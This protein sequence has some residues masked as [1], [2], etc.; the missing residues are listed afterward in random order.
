MKKQN[1]ILLSIAALILIWCSCNKKE[2]AVSPPLPGNE[3][4]TT[5]IISATNTTDPADTPSARWIQ[6]DPTGTNLPDTSHAILNLKKNASYNVSVY[7]L[8][9]L[10]DVTSEIKDRQ[11]YHLICFDISSSLNLTVLQTDHDANNPPLKIG[12]TDMFTTT[13]ASTGRMEVTLHHQ[14]NVKNGDCAPGSIDMDC[15]FSVNIIN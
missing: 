14:P 6:L 7:F 10:S 8:D 4:L 11:N 13:S 15:T 12:L 9:S 5:M 1:F 2:K 3:A